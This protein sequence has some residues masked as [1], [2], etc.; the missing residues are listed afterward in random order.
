[1]VAA[2][3]WVV[4]TFWQLFCCDMVLMGILLEFDGTT[5]C[6]KEACWKA[7]MLS[8]I[9]ILIESLENTKAVVSGDSQSAT[10]LDYAVASAG[11][12]MLETAPL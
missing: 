8:F 9:W 6:L 12:R 5:E 11:H 10:L 7:V 1:V 2:R 3:A 4:V